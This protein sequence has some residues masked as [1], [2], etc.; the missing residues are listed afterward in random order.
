MRNDEVLLRVKGQRNILREII[1]G[2]LTGLVTFGV[3]M[4]FYKGLLKEG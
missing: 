1:I 2:R 3:E 4:A